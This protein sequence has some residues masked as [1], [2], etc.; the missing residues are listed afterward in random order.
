M[1][2]VDKTLRA[3]VEEMFEL[4][5]THEGVGLAATQ[6]DLPLR[7][8]VMNQA[9]DPGEAESHVFI[10]PVITR[11]AGTSEQEEGCLSLPKLFAPVRR[12]DKVHVTAFN[13]KGEEFSGEVGG[14]FGR[15]IQHETDHLDGVLFI[16]RLSE[17]AR[18]GVA[19]DVAKFERH[20]AE[21]RAAG[22][23]PDDAA[24]L[25]RLKELE[26]RYC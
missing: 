9:S 2:R 16:D 17:A 11:P 25:A 23:I 10:N 12:P 22:E 20:F 6:V 8:F 24:I 1:R 7:L 19:E 4:M 5:F 14:F 15:I 13:L 3:M 18:L 26:G 21:D